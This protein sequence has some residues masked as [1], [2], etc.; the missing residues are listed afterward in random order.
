[1]TYRYRRWWQV[2]A[3]VLAVIMVVLV[4]AM[5]NY[6]GDSA[7][8]DTPP[9]YEGT[10]LDDVAPD[11]RLVDH[12]GVRVA[13]SDFRGKVVVLT[14]LDSQC[15]ETCPLTATH[16]RLARQMLSEEAASVVFIGINVNLEANSVADV[17]ATTKKWRLDEI[18]TWHFLTGSAEELEPV[19]QAYNIMVIPE[20]DEIQH[21]PGVF[22]IDPAGQKRRYV[23][24]PFD[25]TGQPQWTAP[26]HELLVKHIR[27]LLGQGWQQTP[28]LAGSQ[29]KVAALTDGLAWPF[30]D[31]P[32]AWRAARVGR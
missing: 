3:V 23:S 13:L 26:L 11:F 31:G 15:Q 12:Q 6:E 24:T 22:L 4:L 32:A 28:D 29:I 7:A 14:F 8:L 1:M 30:S 27:E 21:T 25:E 9:A 5:A 10:E 17:L 18:P 19:W 2:A 16:L 20:Q